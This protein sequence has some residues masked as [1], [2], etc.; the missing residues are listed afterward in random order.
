MIG[1]KSMKQTSIAIGVICIICTAIVMTGC[2]GSE[3]S[4]S[5]YGTG[6]VVIINDEM[7]ARDFGYLYV[8]GDVKNTGNTMLET[9]EI[10]VTFYDENGV[11]VGEG[12][13]L[14]G[15]IWPGETDDFSAIYRGGKQQLVT[16]TGNSYT[17]E[18]A[19]PIYDN[20]KE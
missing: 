10:R 6:S 15:G 13:S 14:V 16:R 12:N 17:V 8:E 9:A 5:K 11:T 3:S 7:V 1:Q 20:R 18:I 4:N 2:I 19:H